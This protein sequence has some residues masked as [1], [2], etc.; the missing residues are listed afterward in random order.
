ME[1]IQEEIG[2][3]VWFNPLALNKANANATTIKRFIYKSYLIDDF[4]LPFTS[5][6]SC[7]GHCTEILF[8][9]KAVRFSAFLILDF[10]FTD[11]S[12]GSI[13]KARHALK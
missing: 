4:V 12:V 9:L 11:V 10:Y 3:Y 2:L 13:A 6:K 1:Y 8:F 5:M 7:V